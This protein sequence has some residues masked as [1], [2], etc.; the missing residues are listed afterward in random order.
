MAVTVV[1]KCNLP[2]IGYILLDL[3]YSI[4][5]SMLPCDLGVL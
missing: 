3:T 4:D 2:N 5:W 1:C